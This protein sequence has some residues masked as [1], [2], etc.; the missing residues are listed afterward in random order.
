VPPG[1]IGPDARVLIRI[2]TCVWG[3]WA[4]ARVPPRAGR[5]L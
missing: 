1:P 3:V 2:V 5:H 4:L